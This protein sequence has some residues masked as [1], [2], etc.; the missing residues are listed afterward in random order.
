MICSA[1]PPELQIR[2][3]FTVLV[4]ACT[5][6][7]SMTRFGS[8]PPSLVEMEMFAMGALVALAE[9]KTF[10]VPPLDQKVRKLW[11][12]PV[13][14]EK[15]FKGTVIESPGASEAPTAGNLEDVKAPLAPTLVTGAPLKVVSEVLVYTTISPGS[16][17]FGFKV[18]AKPVKVSVCE[19]A[20]DKIMAAERP[21]EEPVPPTTIPPKSTSVGA[22]LRNAD[23]L[24]V[25]PCRVIGSTFEYFATPL[26]VVMVR[27]VV[28][29]PGLTVPKEA[30]C[31]SL[32]E[33]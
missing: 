16:S 25:V 26:T 15:K 2:M 12:A 14:L 7:K 31:A 28:L 8:H 19:P 1:E 30:F 22:T 18:Q 23:L 17:E 20:L 11:N 29:T 32:I 5:L 3:L 4:P 27:D 24:T 13:S 6:P 10:C 21:V 33:V 9:K